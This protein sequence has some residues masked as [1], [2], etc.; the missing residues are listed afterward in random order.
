MANCKVRPQRDC[1]L[2]L[3]GDGLSSCFSTFRSEITCGPGQSHWRMRAQ[4]VFQSRINARLP[5]R[6]R[7]LKSGHHVG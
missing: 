6:A 1:A 7:G 4:P 3:W 2:A 5:A